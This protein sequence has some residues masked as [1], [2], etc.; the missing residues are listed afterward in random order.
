MGVTVAI[1]MLSV[2]LVV[3][4]LVVAVA[5]IPVASLD[6]AL[7]LA[8]V[9]PV[10]LPLTLGGAAVAVTTVP[11]AAVGQAVL[12]AISVSDI[13]EGATITAGRGGGRRGLLR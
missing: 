10:E 11:F 1:V 5:M 12:V 4:V 8:P 3:E 6:V 2:V 9:V 13:G 7:V